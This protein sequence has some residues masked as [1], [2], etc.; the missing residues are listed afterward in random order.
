MFDF[1]RRTRKCPKCGSDVPVGM[2]FCPNC[3][4]KIVEPEARKEQPKQPAPGPAA[5]RQAQAAPGE[6][7]PP[8]QIMKCPNCGTELGQGEKYCTN[9]G[10]NIEVWKR[11]RTAQRADTG[12]Y[13]TRKRF[14]SFEG[15]SLEG[16][17]PAAAMYLI[18]G[19]WNIVLAG[20]SLFG[21]VEVFYPSPFDSVLA[22]R[23]I[24]IGLGIALFVA[25]FGLMRVNSPL[26]LLG[27]LALI[28]S[29]PLSVYQIFYSL[30]AEFVPTPSG[31]HQLENLLTGF[32]GILVSA[33]GLLQTLRVRKYFF[34]SEE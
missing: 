11:R 16:V 31:T 4:T 20:L 23:I 13:V 15:Y 34:P 22:S 3:G 33:I 25:A 5:P 9:C 28:I 26:Y 10:F 32:L 27:I 14:F 2:G 1:G 12:Y 7:P 17:T 18:W 30:N 24:L 8:P 21:Q 19:A 6:V 29:V